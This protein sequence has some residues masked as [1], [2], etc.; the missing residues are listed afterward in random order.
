MSAHTIPHTCE[1][2]ECRAA[3]LGKRFQRFCSTACWYVHA[4]RERAGRAPVAALVTRAA[5]AKRDARTQIRNKFGRLRPREREIF[6]A[7][8]V[9]AYRRGY[10]RGRS[11]AHGSTP[12]EQI[13][14]LR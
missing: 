3:F 2:A 11:G 12:L 1:R 8:Y 4:S 7:A 14:A 6:R 10:A 13:K 9:M 5:A